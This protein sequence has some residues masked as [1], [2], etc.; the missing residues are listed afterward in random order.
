M[1]I[2]I[3]I[4]KMISITQINPRRYLSDNLLLLAEVVQEVRAANV[5]LDS[6]QV[7]FSVN[8]HLLQKLLEVRL[9]R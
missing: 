4:F 2:F 6:V 3:K 8:L 9:A 7:L 1:D 5:P